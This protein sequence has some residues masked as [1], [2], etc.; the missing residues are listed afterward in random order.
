MAEMREQT[1][2]GAIE[3]MER[4]YKSHW[5]GGRSWTMLRQSTGLVGDGE[6]PEHVR[7]VKK[8]WCVEGKDTCR[9]PGEKLR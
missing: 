1:P 2:Q 4:G 8:L 3:E 9:C 5:P 6:W 7:T